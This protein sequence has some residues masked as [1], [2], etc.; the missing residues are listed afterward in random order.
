MEFKLT[1]KLLSDWGPYDKSKNKVLLYS[2]GNAD[3]AHSPALP[4]DIDDHIARRKAISI[5]ER[6]GFYYK[7]HFPYCGDRAGEIARDWSPAYMESSEVI[8]NIISDVKLDISKQE[9]YLRN[10]ISHVII[11]SCHGGN[12]FLKDEQVN[13]ANALGVPVLYILPFQGVRVT[14]E[15]L[16][17]IFVSH[18]DIAEHSIASYLGLLDKAKLDMVNEIAQKDPEDAL[19]RWPTIAGLGGFRLFGGSRYDALRKRTE[20]HS[21]S[22]NRFLKERRMIADTQLG[23]RIFE[24]SITN[25]IE[26]INAFLDKN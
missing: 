21:I 19:K 7:G 1:E 15:K 22:A 24:L 25:A 3:E 18:A 6:T 20:N 9:R 2:I 23:E 16:G 8:N 13:L 5:A 14:D 11:V 12:N 4:R 10:E 26:E 17:E